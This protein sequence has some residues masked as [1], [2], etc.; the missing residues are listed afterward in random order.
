MAAVSGQSVVVQGFMLGSVLTLET[1]VP[2]DM[3]TLRLLLEKSSLEPIL[4]LA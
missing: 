2:P 3:V 4:C 1:D